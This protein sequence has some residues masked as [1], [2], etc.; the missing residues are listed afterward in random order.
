MR[1]F[2]FLFFMC[3]INVCIA[4]ADDYP[5][6]RSKRE[7]FSRIQEKDIRND[8][9][10]FS[11]GGLDESVGKLPLQTIPIASSGSNSIVFAGNDITV[12]IKAAT[13]D[14][15]QHKLGLYDEKFLIKIDNRPYFGDYGKIPR[16]YISKV[17]V[18]IGADTVA[19]PAAAYSDLYNPV[20][21]FYE[22]GVQKSQN[23]VLLSA[24]GHRIY[25]Y[26]LKRDATGSYEVTWVIQDKKYLRRVV[27]FGFL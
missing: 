14:K 7:I 27:D 15:K 5:D 11:M 19:I 24:D 20:F 10:T 22:G 2:A 26:M 12:N 16:T 25:V 1:V 17:M 4:Q 13:F 18:T 9:A 3:F 23:K 8:I 6:T 21:S